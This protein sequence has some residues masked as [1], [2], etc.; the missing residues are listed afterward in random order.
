MTEGKDSETIR[1]ITT[2]TR[3]PR[4]HEHR[5]ARASVSPRAAGAGRPDGVGVA[6]VSA[7]R[8]DGDLQVGELPASAVV[9]ERAADGTGAAALVSRMW[10][11][12]LGRIGAAGAWRVV[13]AGSEAERDRPLAAFRGVDAPDGGGA[14]VVAGA[15]GTVAGVAAP[16]PG[17]VGR[18]G[19]PSECEHGR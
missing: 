9:L 1:G 10:A 3:G 6:A 5:R 17:P 18:D 13:R 4:V 14:A 16:G 11:D 7:L 19:L 2:P 12:V 8:G 15:A